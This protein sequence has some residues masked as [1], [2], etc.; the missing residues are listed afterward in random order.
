MGI[1]VGK[2][3]KCGNLQIIEDYYTINEKSHK[4]KD[5]YCDHEHWVIDSY[6]KVYSYECEKCGCHNRFE[7]DVKCDRY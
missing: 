3:K 5:F 1:Y 6:T 7:E 4:E 2:C